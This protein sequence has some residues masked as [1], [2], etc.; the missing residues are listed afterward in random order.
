[1]GII[2]LGPEFDFSKLK[3]N[4]PNGKQGGSY[5]CK[6]LYD[7]DELLIQTPK[8]M[9]KNGFPKGDNQGYIDIIVESNNDFHNW[10]IALEDHIKNIINDKQILWFD[11]NQYHLS[12]N[13][14][15]TIIFRE[16]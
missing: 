7:D 4:N 15:Q 14:Y 5:F 3:L 8:S 11:N 13:Y 12:L 2:K 6:L 10:I 1:M 9:S 16:R